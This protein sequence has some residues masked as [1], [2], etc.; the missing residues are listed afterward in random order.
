[1]KFMY[2]LMIMMFS[3]MISAPLC[4][5]DGNQPEKLGRLL[6]MVKNCI[7]SLR[8]GRDVDPEAVKIL[9]DRCVLEGRLEWYTAIEKAQD[10]K[11]QERLKAENQRRHPNSGKSH[12]QRKLQFI[13]DNE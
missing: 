3:T 10:T 5:M 13:D 8:E 1:M 4:A 2:Y 12:G 11:E 6:R 7:Q 9:K